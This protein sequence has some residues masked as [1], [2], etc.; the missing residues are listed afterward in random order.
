MGVPTQEFEFPSTNR[1]QIYRSYER[2]VRLARR[3]NTNVCNF[4]RELREIGLSVGKILEPILR[5]FDL[6]QQKNLSLALKLDRHTLRIPWELAI[7]ENKDEG[8]LCER[9]SI[10][11]ARE[12]SSKEGFELLR[13]RKVHRAL[14]VGIN[15]KRCKRCLPLDFAEKEAAGVASYLNR[16]G[17]GYGLSVARLIGNRAKKQRLERE[18]QKGVNVFH[19]TGHATMSG[20]I[21]EIYVGRGTKLT[22]EELLRMCVN[23]GVP[24]PTFSFINACQTVLEKSARWEAYNWAYTMADRGGRACIGTFW[25]VPD[26]ETSLT[27]SKRF[28]KEFFARKKTLGESMRRARLETKSVEDDSS[29][30]TWPAYVLYGRP[31]IRS[32]DVMI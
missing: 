6:L 11:R 21:G 1:R 10:G 13:P 2:I 12:V 5:H 24:T 20:R 14:V 32:K 30:L 17:K 19:F 28:Y 22:A 4:E 3:S 25:S 7:C 27:F 29:I 16:F 9:V 26:D 18:I 31:T 8:F 23:A 15:Y